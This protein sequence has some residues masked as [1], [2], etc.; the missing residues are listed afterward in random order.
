MVITLI[1]GILISEADEGVSTITASS[2]LA[3][4]VNIKKVTSKKNKSTIGVM[5]NVG[6]VLF[7]FTLGIL[8]G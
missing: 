3:V 8:S 5:S 7:T 4:A 6:F 2:G 1:S